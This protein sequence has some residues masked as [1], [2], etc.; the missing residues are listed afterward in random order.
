[1]RYLGRERLRRPIEEESC[2]GLRVDRRGNLNV[3]EEKWR[4]TF[5]GVGH[6]G[7]E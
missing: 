3:G 5:C 2:V 6:F 1:M 7:V 4:N